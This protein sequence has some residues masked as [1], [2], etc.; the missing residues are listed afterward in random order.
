[1]EIKYYQYFQLFSLL[2]ALI[3]RKRLNSFSLGI[4]IPI[5]ILD[6]LT[7]I[8]GSNHLSVFHTRGNYFVYNIYFILST[9][10]F[11]LLFASMLD[12]T[13]RDKRR[14]LGSGVILETFLLINY[15]FIQGQTEF[16]TFSAQLI[17]LACIILSCLVLTRL[18]VR[19]DDES[20]LLHDPVFW[21]NAVLLL[22]NLVS[23]IV[24][25]M[26][27]FIV[28]NKLE[29]AN[30]NLYRAIMPAANAILYSGYSYAF[31]LCQLQTRK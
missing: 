29:I 11:F 25:G 10:L 26:H 18:A 31:L 21:I 2:L 20:G 13:P 14:L 1:M 28:E 5:L 12:G 6:N 16:D 7:E 22:F 17:C 3:C 30:L 9:P 27:K 4:M 15:F 8:L 19:K 24:L 23:L